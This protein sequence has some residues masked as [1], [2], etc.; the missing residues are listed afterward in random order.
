MK[1]SCLRKTV[2]SSV[3]VGILFISGLTFTSNLFASSEEHNREQAKEHAKEKIAEVKNAIAEN[4]NAV[5]L[6]VS[7][8]T[9]GAC[10][11]KVKTALEGVDGVIKAKVMT[12]AGRAIVSTEEGK[13]ETEKLIKAVKK[14][15]FGAEAS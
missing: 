13:V 6:K 9:C 15:G 14:A 2:I 3:I 10:A 5:I 11:N 1:N 8:M 7:G 4:T 12:K